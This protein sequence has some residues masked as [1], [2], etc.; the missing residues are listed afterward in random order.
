M[1][2]I[3]VCHGKSC[4]PAGAARLLKKLKSC[5][6][7]EDISFVERTCC[8]RCEHSI[9]IQIDD[10]TIISDLSLSNLEERF[11]NDPAA[12]IRK[13]RQN[14]EGAREKLETFLADDLV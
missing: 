8:G 5:Y 7:D 4:G 6:G 12:A 11:T 1:K 10:D 13:A 3:A 9:S 14:E 2:K